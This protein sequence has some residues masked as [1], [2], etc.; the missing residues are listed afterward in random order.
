MFKG[1]SKEPSC[2]SEIE[3]ECQSR[4]PDQTLAQPSIQI[5]FKPK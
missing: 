4:L 3:P 2:P 5:P 1:M